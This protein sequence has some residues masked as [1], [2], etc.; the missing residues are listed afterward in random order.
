[1]IGKNVVLR[2]RRCLIML[3]LTAILC[4]LPFAG[5]SAQI[6][7]GVKGGIDASE[8]SF[9]GDV[10]KKSNRMGYFIGPVL[11]FPLLGLGFD[12][13]ALYAK[14]NVELNGSIEG[15]EG[16]YKVSD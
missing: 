9:S 10:F 4:H 3:A 7:L 16:E 11:K 1:M 5:A 14:R 13:Y 15:E 2:G 6:K 8:M 12:I